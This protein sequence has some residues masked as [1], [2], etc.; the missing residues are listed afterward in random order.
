MQRV[1]VVSVGE[2]R[3]F[4]RP[5]ASKAQALKVLE[6]AAEVVE[7]YKGWS[8]MRLSQFPDHSRMWLDRL[9]DECADVIQATCNLMAAVGVDDAGRAMARCEARN[10]KR[11]R[12]TGGED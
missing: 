11:G 10:R 5:E 6:E 2:V 9:L 1:R 7:A 8:A 3:C 12:I 4:D